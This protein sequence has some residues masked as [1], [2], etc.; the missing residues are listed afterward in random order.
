MCEVDLFSKDV[1]LIGLPRACF[2]GCSV[3]VV[4]VLLKRLVLSVFGF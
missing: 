3:S 2:I 1:S 4:D